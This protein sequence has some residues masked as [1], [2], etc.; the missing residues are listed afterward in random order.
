MNI[1]QIDKFFLQLPSR[2][3][4]ISSQVQ[5]MGTA[6]REA[7]A[8]MLE[9]RTNPAVAFL[10][11]LEPANDLERQWAQRYARYKQRFTELQAEIDQAG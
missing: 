6:K 2:M 11:G 4:S 8:R 9:L 1:D 3:E 5:R 10:E 7:Q